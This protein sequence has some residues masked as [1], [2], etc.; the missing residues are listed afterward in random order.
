MSQFARDGHVYM[1]DS[2]LT[3]FIK[4]GGKL[5]YSLIG[6][7]KATTFTG[8]CNY[9]DTL[10][11]RPIESAPFMPS[12]ESAFLLAYRG[13]CRE[14]YAKRFQSELIKLLRKGDK[15]KSKEAQENFQAFTDIYESGV[16]AGLSDLQ[17][18][19]GIYDTKL[20]AGD[21]S[22]VSYY[23]VSFDRVPDFMCS[24]ALLL[25]M[26]FG[27]NPLQTPSQFMQLGNRL[28]QCTFS[29]IGADSGGYV[30]FSWI[31]ENSHGMKFIG[32]LD[33]CSDE[34]IPHAIVRFAFEFFENI[35]ISPTWWEGLKKS[36][37]ERLQKRTETGLSPME[38]RSPKCLMDDGL[39]VVEWKVVARE[40]HLIH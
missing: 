8:F 39:R 17:H 5:R 7:K 33:V 27:G 23:A 14:I 3:S 1:L 37:R 24:S 25:E 12:R 11:F 28:L 10:T 38:E 20:L 15:G 40:K 29:L 16:Q 4:T 6:V 22:D 31:G 18:H 36:D 19:K 35:A 13:I 32:S 34:E 26:D 2:H 30:V 21:Y 9:H